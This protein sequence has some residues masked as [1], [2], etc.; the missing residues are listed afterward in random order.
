GGVNLKG[1]RGFESP[2]LRQPVCLTG[3]FGGYRHKGPAFAANVS[4]DETRERDMLASNRLAF[5]FFLCRALMQSPLSEKP[6]R[7][8]KRCQA[9]AW[10]QPIEG[11]SFTARQ[12]AALVGPVERQIEFGETCCGEF[13]R[14]SAVQD[15]VDQLGAEKGEV[16]EAPDI[17]T[18]DAL[19][20]G[21]FPQRSGAPRGQLLEPR[22]SARDRL[23]Q[24]G[25]AS[26][27]V[28]LYCHCR[29][30]QPHF[31]TAAPEGHRRCK[32]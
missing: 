16:D 10:T 6:K 4:L 28:V 7:S 23:D 31:D 20:L 11:R 24:R 17:A 13:D 15:R 22:S 14:L 30:H 26:R 2:S 9:L 29:Q 27:G 12:Q 3:A 18:G 8:M 5:A 32:L 19:A 25:V 1:D 21:Q